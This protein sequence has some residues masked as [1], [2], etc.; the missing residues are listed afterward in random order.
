[1]PQVATVSLKSLTSELLGSWDKGIEMA[2]QETGTTKN[3]PDFKVRIPARSK[4]AC[5]SGRNERVDFPTALMTPLAPPLARGV[6]STP[7]L[8]I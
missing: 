4:A 8:V 2:L 3:T 5:Q 7:L 6:G 1:M